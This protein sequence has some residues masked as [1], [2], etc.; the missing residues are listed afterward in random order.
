MSGST[1]SPLP[2][3][4]AW[5]SSRCTSSAETVVSSTSSRWMDWIPILTS[6]ALLSSAGT[7]PA[8]DAAPGQPGHQLLGSVLGNGPVGA[9]PVGGAD[10]GHADQPDAEQVRL[11]VAHPGV[12]ADDLAD[13]VGVV[14]H[15][16]V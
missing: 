4:S 9:Q 14:P 13:H 5:L 6:T 7:R 2:S 3:D 16:L 8:A 15:G 12:L 10:P 1:N 11:G